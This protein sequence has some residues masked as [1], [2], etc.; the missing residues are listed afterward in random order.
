M[1][2]LELESY[3]SSWVISYIVSV[4]VRASTIISEAPYF[5][6]SV[7]SWESALISP[8][9]SKWS[10]LPYGHQPNLASPSRT[11][12]VTLTRARSSFHLTSHSL[13]TSG[14]GE[15]HEGKEEEE[16]DPLLH[17]VLLQQDQI[18]SVS[19]NEEDYRVTQ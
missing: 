9:T 16:E 1:S 4:I 12:A 14:G 10:D 3:G 19:K 11:L 8:Y 15:N 6:T 2:Y 18:Q 13:P 7:E 5:M 17:R